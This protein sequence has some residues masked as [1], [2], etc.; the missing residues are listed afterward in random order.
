MLKRLHISDTTR[1]ILAVIGIL[2]ALAGVIWLFSKAVVYVLP[3]L[4]AILISAMIEPIVRFFA[5]LF[6]GRRWPGTLISI[7]LIVLPVLG[8]LLLI[9]YRVCMEFY[10]LA[11]YVPDI[12][13][14]VINWV[15]G[16]I[17][18]NE[19]LSAAISTDSREFIFDLLGQLGIT[20]SSALNA[21]LQTAIGLLKYIPSAII[22]I[23]V[24]FISTFFIT[25]DKP[26]IR[27]ALSKQCPDRWRG[28]MHNLNDNIFHAVF[29]YIKAQTT[30]VAIAYVYLI[31]SL[32]VIKADYAWLLA[33]LISLLDAI[34]GVGVAIVLIP[35]AIIALL[36]GNSFTGIVLIITT[37]VIFTTRQLLEP[38]ILGKRVGIHPL[39]TMAAIYI[40]FKIFGIIGMILGP[41]FVVIIWN[42]LKYVMHNKPFGEFVKNG[43]GQK[44]ADEA[45]ADAIAVPEEKEGPAE[46]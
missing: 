44:H 1:N 26:K 12:V 21:V 13:K 25:L 32:S 40:G 10:N 37:A 28:F 24:M 17:K 14:N 39:A 30:L 16:I 35:W 4:L 27:A 38:R 34:P 45:A 3:F 41:I 6:R 29:S 11:I 8:V 2:L 31:I 33:L 22:F 5:K 42:V 7:I 43:F 15:D 23:F 46:E 18:S 20:V 9:I 36:S 19:L